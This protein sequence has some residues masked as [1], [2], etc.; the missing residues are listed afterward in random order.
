MRA[1]A[2]A[3]FLAAMLSGTDAIAETFE[4]KEFITVYAA[5]ATVAGSSFVY[6]IGNAIHLADRVRP[7]P[8]WIVGGL[9][10]GITSVVAGI[11]EIGIGLL[12][13]QLDEGGGSADALVWLLSGGLA[14][15]SGSLNVTFT[16]AASGMPRKSRIDWIAP[17]SAPRDPWSIQIVPAVIAARDGPLPAIALAASW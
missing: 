10:S 3:A 6:F 2:T 16:V 8:A 1:P 11:G 14:F 13:L 4:S 15:L 9:T 5:A 7:R 17:P 12:I